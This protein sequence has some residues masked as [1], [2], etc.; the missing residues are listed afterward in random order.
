M[1]SLLNSFWS[2]WLMRGADEVREVRP[3]RYVPRL[4]PSCLQLISS[5][6]RVLSV[7]LYGSWVDV[8]DLTPQQRDELVESFKY[9]GTGSYIVING[10]QVR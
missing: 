10:K 3:M 8:E 9:V 2:W 5:G 6:S 4:L 1:G 7:R